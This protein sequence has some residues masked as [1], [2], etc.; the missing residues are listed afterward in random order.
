[1]MGGCV[2]PK[3]P[4]L[5]PGASCPAHCSEKRSGCGPTAYALAYPYVLAICVQ[6]FRV[7]LHPLFC[8]RLTLK[9]HVIGLPY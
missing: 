5:F 9:L 8:V 3:Y 2:L 7:N 6:V 1:M 4:L